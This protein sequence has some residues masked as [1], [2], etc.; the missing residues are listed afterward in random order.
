MALSDILD[1]LQHDLGKHLALPLRMLPADADEA[2][3]RAAL[4][5]ALWRTRRG[6]SG[7]QDAESLW[8]ASRAA[9]AEHL[10]PAAF[11]PLI[12]AIERALAWR[13]RVEGPLSRR[14]VEADL[15]AVG[16]AIRALRNE[17]DDG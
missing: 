2:T 7:V 16:D 4:R 8:V 12:A 6:P 1:D 5:T 10:D 14:A 13:S 17:L 15:V 11:A 9:L 3:V